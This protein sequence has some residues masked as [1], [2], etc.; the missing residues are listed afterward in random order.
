MR[1]V[2]PVASESGGLFTSRSDTVSPLT[3]STSVPRLRPSV[4]GL[5]SILS[6]GPMSATSIPRSR[7]TSAL[8]G[9]RTTLGLLGNSKSTW[10]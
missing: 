2:S 4:I 6:S 3:T 10:A 8:V 9:M 5:S 7:N 1:T